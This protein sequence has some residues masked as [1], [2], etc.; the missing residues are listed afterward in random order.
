VKPTAGL[1]LRESSSPTVQRAI[2][3]ISKRYARKFTA[4]QSERYQKTGKIFVAKK[5]EK[6]LSG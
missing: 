3:T 5:E 1:T 6:N 4:C 2:Y